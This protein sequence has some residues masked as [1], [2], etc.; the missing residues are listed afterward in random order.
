MNNRTTL[1]ARR[2]ARRL[3]QLAPLAAWQARKQL[4]LEVQLIDADF[5]GDIDQPP[6][7]AAD[8]YKLEMWLRLHKPP[9]F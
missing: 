3:A 6:L 4:A 5:D 8:H 1:T 7:T 9:T 2:N